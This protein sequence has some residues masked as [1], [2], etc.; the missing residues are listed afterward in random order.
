[1]EVALF[2]VSSPEGLPL[3][4]L[5][6]S[7][8]WADPIEDMSGPGMGSVAQ[9]CNHYL[10]AP[11]TETGSLRNALLCLHAGADKEATGLFP[12]AL[13][14]SKLGWFFTAMP[15]CFRPYVKLLSGTKGK[16]EGFVCLSHKITSI[17]YSWSEYGK[18]R[19]ERSSPRPT[20]FDHRR[21]HLFIYFRNH[22]KVWLYI[23][24]VAHE[25][26]L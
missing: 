20:Y 6:P 1:M 10:M 15:P 8:D 7:S 24:S 5:G 2:I 4:A 26:G 23:A 19:K 25:A 9:I 12:T 13:G 21:V 11:A 14:S 22:L 17:L 16:C 3:L 18:H